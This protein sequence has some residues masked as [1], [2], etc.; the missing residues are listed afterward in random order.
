MEL[1]EIHDCQ[2]V[3]PKFEILHDASFEEAAKNDEIPPDLL[4]RYVRNTISSM[5]SVTQKSHHRYPLKM[6]LEEM[7]KSIVTKF[8]VLRD[9]NKKTNYVSDL[10]P[11]NTYSLFQGQISRPK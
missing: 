6:E 5:D 4:L 7:A 2:Y 10:S 1:Q 8:P 3:G 11:Q 9:T